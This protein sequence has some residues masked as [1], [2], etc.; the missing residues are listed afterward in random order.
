MALSAAQTISVYHAC[1]LWASGGTRYRY[2]FNAYSMTDI[3]DMSLTWDYSTVK[4]KIDLRLA[5]LTA[6]EVT[7]LGT[8]IT[9]FDD[10]RSSSFK[11]DG[12]GDGIILDDEVEHKK[13]TEA[14]TQMV[15]FEV[16]KVDA[17]DLNATGGFGCGRVV[18]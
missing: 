2:K 5:A 6:D 18:R 7:W 14:I 12:S 4:T 17:S 3:A 13:A 1:G 10:T 15:G 16:E 11:K 8:Y 9:T